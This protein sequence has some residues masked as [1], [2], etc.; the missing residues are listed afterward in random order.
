M[1]LMNRRQKISLYFSCVCL[2]FIGR[3]AINGSYFIF[4]VFPYVS[5]GVLTYIN[6]FTSHWGS[7]VFA[8]MA[9]ELFPDHFSLRMRRAL[10]ALT[11]VILVL[12][13]V[14]PAT[15]YSH[16]YVISDILCL[17]VLGYAYYATR[18][19]PSL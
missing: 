16:H 19:A 9:R 13:T 11:A 12:I 18:A 2:I 7:L 8:L 5:E 17:F 6:Y 14:I 3:I 15:I 4:E 10:I 1:F